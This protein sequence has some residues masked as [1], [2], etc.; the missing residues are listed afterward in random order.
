[1]YKRQLKHWVLAGEELFQT[2]T[3]IQKSLYLP[4][5]SKN[6]RISIPA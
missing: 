3:V 4:L 1:M 6:L 5:V 2:P